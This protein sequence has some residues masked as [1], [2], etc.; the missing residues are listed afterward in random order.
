M[1]WA[2]TNGLTY[3]KAGVLQCVKDQYALL[4]QNA[5]VAAVDSVPGNMIPGWGNKAQSDELILA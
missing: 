5:Q 3:K 1:A 4:K 2:K